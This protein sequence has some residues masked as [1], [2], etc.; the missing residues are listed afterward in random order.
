MKLNTLIHDLRLA[1]K[2]LLH[3]GKQ[4]HATLSMMQGMYV[5]QPLHNEMIAGI[6]TT[7]TI[8]PDGC[9]YQVTRTVYI[10]NIPEC[11]ETW[12][13]TYGWHSNGHLIEIGGDRYCIFDAASKSMYLEI[14]TEQGKT[15]IE[16]FIKISKT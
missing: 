4:H 7:L 11:E 8:K 12:L 3:F 15:M 6:D 13:A 2:I 14:L 1:I 9:L 10:S 16:L 5:R